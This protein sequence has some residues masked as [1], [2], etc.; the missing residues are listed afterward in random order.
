VYLDMKEEDGLS[1]VWLLLFLVCRPNVCACVGQVF[2]AETHPW[3][4]TFIQ[5][6][7]STVA[8]VPGEASAK[9]SAGNPPTRTSCSRGPVQKGARSVGDSSAS[10]GAG[11]CG[12]TRPARSNSSS[13]CCGILGG[14]AA[15][16]RGGVGAFAVGGVVETKEP[17]H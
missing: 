16:G 6:G 11:R 1:A 2:H 7:G 14:I 9:D 4:F 12:A 13:C 17:L 10:E 5:N 15:G 8:F 3:L